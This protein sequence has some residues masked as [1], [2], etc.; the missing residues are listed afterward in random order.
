MRDEEL[1]PQNMKQ[2]DADSGILVAAIH[3]VVHSYSVPCI[4]NE[5]IV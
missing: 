2:L 3:V 1:Q 5:M 4:A